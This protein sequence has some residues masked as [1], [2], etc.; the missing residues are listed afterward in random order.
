MGR[1]DM[2]LF[3][4]QYAGIAAEPHKPDESVHIVIKESGIVVKH[5]RLIQGRQ[6]EAFRFLYH[7]YPLHYSTRQGSQQGIGPVDP[8]CNGGCD[9]SGYLHQFKR[10]FP[11]PFHQ[12]LPVSSLQQAQ[13]LRDPS[14]TGKRPG[15]GGIEGD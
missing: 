15:I 10:P 2:Y 6:L 13:P 1:Y 8:V 12:G 3:P 9:L 5:M 14:D 7:C 11:D 4:G